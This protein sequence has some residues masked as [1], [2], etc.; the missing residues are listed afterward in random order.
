MKYYLNSKQVKLSTLFVR[1]AGIAYFFAII[2]NF[3]WVATNFNSDSYFSLSLSWL[4]LLAV[5][6][7]TISGILVIINNWNFLMIKPS[8]LNLEDKP[9]VAILIPTYNEPIKIVLNT[10]KSVTNQEWPKNKRVIII[11]DDGY[12]ENL[13]KTIEKFKCDNQEKEIIY[14]T[15]HKKGHPL[16]YGDAKAGNLNSALNLIMREYPNIEYIETRDS[17]DLVGSKYFLSYCL[18]TLVNDSELSFV[19]TI[20]QCRVGKNDPFCN[21]ESIFYQRMIPSRYS[22]NAVFPCGSGLVWRL[23]HLKKINGFPIW[24]LVE[25]LQSGFEILKIGGKGA[26]LP[27]V[28]ALGQIAPEDI[29]NFYKQ[30]GTWAL[31]TL[32]LFFYQNPLFTKG[33]S[34][35]QKLQ[36]F[37][38]ESSYLLSF[39]MFIFIST[40]AISLSTGIYPITSSSEDY[41]IH[42]ILFVLSMEI[43]NLAWARGM[44]FKQWRSRRIWFGLMSVFMVAT[45]QALK[46]GSKTKPVYNVTKKFHTFAW[47]WKETLIQKF[48]IVIL[49]TSIIISISRNDN[50]IETLPLIFWALF[51]IYGFSQ[52]V[53]NSWHGVNFRMIQPKNKKYFLS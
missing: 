4:F 38:L 1:L 47:Y 26:F 27:I 7:T 28:G 8:K 10:L 39:A 50:L 12:N 18:N 5:I 2:W 40:I 42:F 11:S 48:V 13:K 41:F 43:Y 30:R 33:L 34:I 17:D 45:F 16:R 37:E 53:K 32:R 36:F 52:V 6:S 35:K 14:H 20:K 29:P 22:A 23:S 9:E 24:N 15:P 25:D 49:S 3:E 31:D 19:Q 21:Q 44:Y 46:H 51:F